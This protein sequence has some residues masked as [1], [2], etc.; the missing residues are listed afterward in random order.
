MGGW[1]YI[2]CCSDRTYYTGCTSNLI[3]RIGLHEVGI[4]STYTRARLPVRLVFSCEFPTIEEAIRAEREIKGWSRAKKEALIAGR[5]DLLH[6]L[7]K[8]R[9]ASASTFRLKHK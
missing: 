7:A 4:G 6:E 9:N 3:Q 8:C 2:L 5:F 1:V